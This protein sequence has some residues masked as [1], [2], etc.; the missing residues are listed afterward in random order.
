LSRAHAW[1]QLQSSPARAP[2]RAPGLLV[3]GGE[4]DLYT[5][6]RPLVLRTGYGLVIDV[7]GDTLGKTSVFMGP[8]ETTDEPAG[9]LSS[10]M[11]SYVGSEYEA[12]KAFVDVPTSKWNPHP[13]DV[14]EIIY[15][16][17]GWY[18]DDWKHRFRVP[19]RL[20][21]SGNWYR[22]DLP[23]GCRVTP[24]GFVD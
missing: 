23:R 24:R 17:V 12:Q 21:T 1:H 5:T 7:D 18:S 11:L 15:F 10:E 22:L 20:S 19:A 16:R 8:I 2:D 14:V 9:E 4:I 6:G 3:L 13:Y